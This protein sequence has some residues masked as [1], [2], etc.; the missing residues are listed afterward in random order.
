[1]GY[2]PNEL[3]TAPPRVGSTIIQQTLRVVK[4]NFNRTGVPGR[5][6][7]LSKL[8]NLVLACY[9]AYRKFCLPPVVGRA[10]YGCRRIWR[11]PPPAQAVTDRAKEVRDMDAGPSHSRR[12]F[13][14]CL[15]A[16][17][18]FSSSDKVS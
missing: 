2:E 11:A 5:P 14:M 10:E 17:M 1:M 8:L 12:M 6:I 16:G 7:V 18:F 3:T 15:L 4:K 13:D 9:T